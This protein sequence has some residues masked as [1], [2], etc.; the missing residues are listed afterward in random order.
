MPL[1]GE[2]LRLYLDSA[3][4]L[5]KA[6]ERRGDYAAADPYPHIVF[7]DLLPSDALDRVLADFPNPS[8]PVWKKY[9]SPYEGKLET[10]GEGHISADTSWLLYQLNSAPFLRFLEQ[11]TGIEGLLPDPYFVGGG[12]HQIPPGGKLGIHADFHRHTKYPLERRLNVLIYLNK[13][14]KDEYGGHLEL[15]D[16]DMKRC[17]QKILPVFNRMVVFTIT[18]WA[19][20]GHPEPLTC[21]DG[22]T[23]KSIALY[24]FTVGR[25][26]GEVKHERGAGDTHFVARPGEVFEEERPGWKDWAKKLVPPIVIDAVKGR[27]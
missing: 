9:K 2:P 18:D 21:P 1:N 4:L 27:R 20:H 6:K 12:L 26:A 10:Q 7:D 13:D 22:M 19:F 15:W 23:R 11:L 8:D 3:D 5:T 16:R 17:V 24:Y 14:W 25:P